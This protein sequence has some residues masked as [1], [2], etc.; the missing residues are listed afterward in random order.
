MN[1]QPVNSGNYTVTVSNYLDI[2]TSVVAVVQ[3][4]PQPATSISIH[5]SGTI[6]VLNWTGNHTL[7]SALSVSGIFSNVPGPVYAG[8]YTNGVTGAA[9]FF[10]LFN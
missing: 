9:Q 3:V 10:R 5:Q 7:Q 4:T 6:V 2:K 1:A 8:P